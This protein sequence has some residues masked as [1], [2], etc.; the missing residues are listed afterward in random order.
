MCYHL[1]NFFN[2][3]RKPEQLK[4]PD[5]W[6]HHD[7]MELKSVEKGARR[8]ESLISPSSRG[9]REYTDHLDEKVPLN[10]NTIDKKNFL[11]SYL[12]DGSQV[13]PDGRN[14]L[15]GRSIKSQ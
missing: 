10:T 4:P 1:F 11:S 5:L 2:R 13:I 14:T 9:S 8:T 15:S 6:I 3:K 12:R 7:Q